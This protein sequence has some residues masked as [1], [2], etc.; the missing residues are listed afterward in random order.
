MISSPV[1][2]QVL[3]STAKY[4]Q[5]GG[6]DKNDL[7]DTKTPPPADELMSVDNVYTQLISLRNHNRALADRIKH[8][9][10]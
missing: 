1:K 6:Y 5:F 10:L 7:S 9:E 4:G 2:R 3:E 8:L